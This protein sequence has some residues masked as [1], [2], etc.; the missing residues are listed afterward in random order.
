MDVRISKEIIK[1]PDANTAVTKKE[2]LTLPTFVHRVYAPKISKRI[3]DGYLITESDNRVTAR[4]ITD[5][6]RYA[7]LK[8]LPRHKVDR[9]MYA[10]PDSWDAIIDNAMKEQSHE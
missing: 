9:I 5:A 4:P 2:P 10:E 3:V 6:D 1:P 8:T 7:F